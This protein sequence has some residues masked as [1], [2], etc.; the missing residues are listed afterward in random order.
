[1]KIKLCGFKK[2]EDINFALNKGCDF[3]GL[4]NISI[5]KRFL[6]SFRI[7]ELVEKLLPERRSQLVVL[8]NHYDEIFLL[9]LKELG[10]SFIQSYLKKE[11]DLLVKEQG[12]SIIKAFNISSEDDI[13]YI[14]SFDLQIYDYILLDTKVEGQLGGTGKAFDWQLFK[15]LKKEI[16][17]DLI[18]AGG[19]NI[20]NICQAIK[21]TE[22]SFVDLAGAVEDKGGNK[23]FEL[24]QGFIEA[25]RAC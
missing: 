23:S 24:I 6:N 12:F 14:K 25:A 4:N 7:L 11:D 19:L 15:I 13:T 2:I 17:S 16:D 20:E 9:K 8:V 18:L 5:S 22:T 21:V 10:V 3:V 1:V